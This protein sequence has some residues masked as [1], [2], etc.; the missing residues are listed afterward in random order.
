MSKN[1]YTRGDKK[2][3]AP[4]IIQAFHDAGQNSDEAA[5]KRLL[6]TYA[7]HLSREQKDGLIEE[8]RRYAAALRESL[9]SK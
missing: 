6:G 9:R 1:P 2:R 7:S 8:F 3:L 4:E 5:F